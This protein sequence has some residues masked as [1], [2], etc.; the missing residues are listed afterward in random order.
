MDSLFP[1][2]LHCRYLFNVKTCIACAEE[3]KADAKLCRHCGI[4]QD[5]VRFLSAAP[6]GI[7]EEPEIESHSIPDAENDDEGLS[8]SELS[9]ISLLILVPTVLLLL[10]EPSLRDQGPLET[11][12]NASASIAGWA[13][14]VLLLLPV[15]LAFPRIRFS[16]TWR[17]TLRRL[18]G[19]FSIWAVAGLIVFGI[20]LSSGLRDTSSQGTQVA[21]SPTTTTQ[22]S[23]PPVSSAQTALANQQ[24]TV[25][26]CKEYQ[27]WYQSRPDANGD[28]IG[29]LTEE[30]TKLVSAFRSVPDAT[31]EQAVINHIAQIRVMKA[32]V[33]SNS[34]KDSIELAASDMYATYVNLWELCNET[35]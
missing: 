28:V 8:F 2:G 34:S 31:I 19:I 13:V 18:A 1:T 23:G 5:D 29:Y 7:V 6:T 35:Y 9:A 32:V 10:I 33:A 3:I 22:Q 20:T 25:D 11:L 4:L 15:L 26:A 30:Q 27:T 16:S 21:P 17:T 14:L 12:A 24:L